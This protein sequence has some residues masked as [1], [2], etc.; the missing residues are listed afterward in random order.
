MEKRRGE[1]ER[2]KRN[3]RK[4]EISILLLTTIVMV[5]MGK[6][7]NVNAATTTF[8]AEQF[9]YDVIFTEIAT[10]EQNT[11][12]IDDEGNLWA[13]GKNMNGSLGIDSNNNGYIYS[14]PIQITSG[15]KFTQVSSGDNF[16]I[17]LD[18]AGN[19]WTWGNGIKVPTK[20]NM[21][22]YISNIKQI[23]A[24]KNFYLVLDNSG[25]V[26]KIQGIGNYSIGKVLGLPV[27]K[28]ISAGRDFC[29][30][31]DNDGN[32]W[33]W[34][35]NEFGQLGRNSQP[36][37]TTISQLEEYRTHTYGANNANIYGFSNAYNLYCNAY[38]NWPGLNKNLQ[39]PYFDDNDN[40]GFK[41]RVGVW[42][43]N[44]MV[45]HTFYAN[46]KLKS[47][48]IDI[49]DKDDYYVE[50]SV[51]LYP[52]TDETFRNAIN[53]YLENYEQE[54]RSRKNLTRNRY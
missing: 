37:Y 10:G 45:E 8:T 27:I 33:S 34:G 17:A 32:I 30:A 23:S 20:Q 9:S 15:T 29:L 6:F 28:Q 18:S 2:M 50:N 31:L 39:L 21:N 12:A 40:A 38:N 48:G 35:N 44:N 22:T 41:G 7:S 49:I 52:P 14:S 13:W 43:S 11:I 36:K 16:S 5:I 4:I 46:F 47:D 25:Q 26:W 24:G 1:K 3:I 53:F 19:I 54:I 42:T 51:I